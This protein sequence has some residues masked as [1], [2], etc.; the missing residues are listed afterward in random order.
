MICLSNILSLL[1][2]KRSS[3][4]W[5]LLYFVTIQ[6]SHTETSR[7]QFIRLLK[8]VENSEW[9]AEQ[10]KIGKLLKKAATENDRELIITILQTQKGIVNVLATQEIAKMSSTDMAPIIEC[11]LQEDAFWKDLTFETDKAAQIQAE[12]QVVVAQSL[13][14]ILN[15]QI[16]IYALYDSKVRKQA[17]SELEHIRVSPNTPYNKKIDNIPNANSQFLT[18]NSAELELSSVARNSTVVSGDE[19]SSPRFQIVPVAIIAVVIIGGIVIGF[20]IQRKRNN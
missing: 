15:R 9:I 14:F 19:Q 20:S 2:I 10:D 8:E 11:I 4:I 7:E 6:M 1:K 17:I 13:S 16:D 18:P 3:L 5:I 12:Q